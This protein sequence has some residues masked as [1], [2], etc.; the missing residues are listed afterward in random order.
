MGQLQ[1]VIRTANEEG[2][3]PLAEIETRL[4]E[5]EERRP[6]KV[7]VNEVIEA[8]GVISKFVYAERE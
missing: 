4:S 2:L 3:E 7:A 6:S 1:D 8:A 5:W